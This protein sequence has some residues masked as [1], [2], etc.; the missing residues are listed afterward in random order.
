MLDRTQYMEQIHE[1]FAVHPICGILGP[2]Q[3][4][5]TT[6]A[7][8]YA[9]T[10][11]GLVHHFDLEHPSDWESLQQPML[12]LGN[13]S[14][15]VIIDEVQYLPSLFPVLR[16]L[17][18][19]QQA[20]YLILGSASPLLIKN[21]SESLAGRIGYI[22]MAPFH[23]DEVPVSNQLLVRGGFPRSYLA[24]S[25]RASMTWRQAFIMS[26]LERDI[27]ALGISIPSTQLRRF[28]MMLCHVHG[29]Q[30]NV[31]QLGTAMGVSGHTIR[32]YLNILQGTFMMRQLQPW[33][34]NLS[35]RQVKM[36]KLYF[37]DTGILLALLSIG[38]YE[39]LIRNPQVGAI[40][41]GFVIEQVLM[42]LNI[43]QEEAY[44]WRTAQGAELDL[45][46]VINGRRIGI[47]IKFSDAPTITPSMRI[48]LEDLKLYHLYVVYP[49]TRKYAL[50]PLITVTPLSMAL[51]LINVC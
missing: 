2:R 32:R 27:P 5:K 6:L 41:E 28:W 48:S 45:L 37:R 24:G 14:G 23:M 38:N 7:L 51:D 30:L 39:V 42:G 16:V 12:A 31:H 49:G 13:L 19:K 50:S 20:Q 4:G 29:Q 9:K 46:I 22:E 15:L 34:E 1:Q 25:D 44:Y 26:F 3:A 47:E 8:Q 21:S 17:S 18:D 10:V 33:Y 35:K 40:W 43:H 11:T 36:P